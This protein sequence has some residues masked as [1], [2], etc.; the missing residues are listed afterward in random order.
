MKACVDTHV[1]IWGLLEQANESQRP[2]V[3]ETKYL[4]GKLEKEKIRIIVPAPVLMETLLGLEHEHH[5]S[6]L[7]RLSRQFLVAPLDARVRSRGGL[8][9]ARRKWRTDSVDGT[10]V[11]TEE[12]KK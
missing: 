4:L 6:F 5:Q 8:D 11:G 1:L 2:M 9:M 3:V 10:P 7:G 12:H